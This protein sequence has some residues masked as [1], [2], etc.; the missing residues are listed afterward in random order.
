MPQ[1]PPQPTQLPTPP[2]SEARSP[3]ASRPPASSRNTRKRTTVK[4]FKKVAILPSKKLPKGCTWRPGTKGVPT[5]AFIHEVRRNRPAAEIKRYQEDVGLVLSTNNF[6]RLVLEI[7]Q[8]MG[9][10]DI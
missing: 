9:K 7:L 8:D 2:R 3:A 10:E 4:S 1:T 5:P 6:H